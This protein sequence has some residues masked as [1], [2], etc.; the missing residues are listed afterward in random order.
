MRWNPCIRGWMENRF[1]HE[2]NQIRPVFTDTILRMARK[3]GAHSSGITELADYHVYS[4]GGRGD[5]YGKE[6]SVLHKFAIALTVE[7]DYH[8][9]S[10]APAAPTVVESARQYLQGRENGC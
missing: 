6:Y 8:M 5:R 4:V 7:M 2:P 9:M 3:L 10:T 1:N